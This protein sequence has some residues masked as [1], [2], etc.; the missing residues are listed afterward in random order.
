VDRSDDR[1]VFA[2]VVQRGSFAGAAAGRGSVLPPAGRATQRHRHC[3]LAPRH[4]HAQVQLTQGIGCAQPK[5]K[6]LFTKAQE[7]QYRPR[8]TEGVACK[9]PASAIGSRSC[10]PWW[11]RAVRC[12]GVRLSPRTQARR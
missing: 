5:P 2:K 8:H 4:Q 10:W 3:R 9:H 1:R 11:Q 6:I 7:S 12:C